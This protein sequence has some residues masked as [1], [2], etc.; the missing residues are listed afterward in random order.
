MKSVEFLVN[1]NT[2]KGTLIFPEKIKEK[3]PAILFIHGWTSFKE[4]SY[5][6]ADGL[7]KAGYFSFIFDMRGHGESEGDINTA[8]IKDFLDD[9]LAAYDYL[10][11]VEDVDKENIS[12]VSSSFGC[13]LAALLSAKRNV[14]KLVLRAPA[15][16]PNDDFNKPKMQTSGIDNPALTC[17]RKEAKNSGETFALEAVSKFDG[18][19]LIIESGK[20][21]TIPHQTVQNYINAV[22][23]KNKLTHILLK[24]AQHSIKDGPFKDEVERILVKWFDKNYIPMN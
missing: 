9:V 4:R 2:L 12:V 14:K 23:N 11:K 16:Y 17:W 1:G 6:Y 3:K 18:N 13:Y 24:D 8:T 15:D 20:D 22:K 21:D 19:I 10:T 7:A 5:Q